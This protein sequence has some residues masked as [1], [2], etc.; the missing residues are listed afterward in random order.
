[1][2]YYI[3]FLMAY[4]KR[5]GTESKILLSIMTSDDTHDRTVQLLEENNYYGMPKDQISFMK[6]EKIPAMTNSKAHFAQK[7]GSLEI[8]TKP[9]GHGDIHTLIHH[10]GNSKKWLEQ[11]KRWV[12]FFQDTNP[13]IFRSFPALLGV[14]RKQ[15]LEAN[16][17]GVPRKVGEAADV[18]VIGHKEGEKDKTFI[19]EWALADLFFKPHGGEPV[20]PDGWSYYQTNINGICLNLSDYHDN[21]N[22]TQGLVAEFINPKYEDETKTK[23]KSAARLETK[24]PDYPRLLESHDR[25]GITK[26]ERLFSFTTCKNDPKEGSNKYKKGIPPECAGT[27]ELEYYQSNIELLKI[28]GVQVEDAPQENLRDFA[29]IG[30]NFGAKVVLKPD[31]G[32]TIREIKSKFK[33][34]NKVSYK[35]TLVLD[36]DVHIENLDLDGSISI[37]SKEKKEVKDL[38]FHEKNYVEFVPIDENETD[39]RLKMRGYKVVGQENIKVIQ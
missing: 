26:I 7:P 11:G 33:G 36:G 1:L 2:N 19:I 38:T 12:C 6:Q 8:E 28:A 35:S 3:D 16:F 25:F 17:V 31:F 9:H 5:V 10:S 21:L 37:A 32:V 24:M 23:F 27:C 20:Q 18:F 34:T 29:G 14:S 22:K 13:L 39:T 30:Y 4:Q 15:N